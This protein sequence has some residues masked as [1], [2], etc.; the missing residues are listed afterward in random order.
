VRSRLSR[1]IALLIVAACGDDPVAPVPAADGPVTVTLTI[2]PDTVPPGGNAVVDL[3]AVLPETQRLTALYLHISEAGFGDSV[4]LPILAN[5]SHAYHIAFEFARVPVEARLHFRLI[6]RVKSVADT[7]EADLLLWD[8]GKPTIVIDMPQVVEPPDSLTYRYQGHDFSELDSLFVRVFNSAG[9]RIDSVMIRQQA[10]FV[11]GMRSIWLP[12]E[13]PLGDSIVVRGTAFDLFGRTRSHTRVAR[14]ADMTPPALTVVVQPSA[15]PVPPCSCPPLVFVP[16]DT[17][18]VRVWGTDRFA[19]RT[20]GFRWMDHTDSVQTAAAVD[21]A[22]F[23]VV[24]PPGTNRLD[25]PIVAWATD[26]SGNVTG[27]NVWA[28][29]VDGIVRP[30]QTLELTGLDGGLL[31]GGGVLDAVR[32]RYYFA[33][34]FDRAVFSFGLNPLEQGLVASFDNIVRTVDLT[35]TGDSL[36]ALLE[37]PARL[38]VWPIETGAGSADTLIVTLATTGARDVRVAA[39]GHALVTSYNLVDVDLSNGAQRLRTTPGPGPLDLA[40]SPDRRYIVQWDERRAAVY[41]SDRDSLGPLRELFSPPPSSMANPGPYVRS[42]GSSLSRNRLFDAQL[43]FVKQVLPDPGQFPE[44]QALSSDGRW[45]F[46]GNWPG[47]WKVDLQSGQ[48]VE[49][50]ILPRPAGRLIP[51]PDG[52]RLIVMYGRWVGVVQLN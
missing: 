28:S 12:P 40:A 50:V 33:T 21:S 14:I 46:V 42:D 30:M 47:Y 24:V 19:L 36:V 45:A 37:Q 29:V 2:T 1:A 39:N 6:A 8:D 25:T 15:H 41:F 11:A 52:Q 26:A 43:N 44:A 48:V 10:A 20:L 31:G 5:G 23:E 18:R 38:V 27:E 51:H 35:P 22:Y 34:A 49:R 32:G 17:I 7:A 4:D 16:G 9:T 3:L 13:A